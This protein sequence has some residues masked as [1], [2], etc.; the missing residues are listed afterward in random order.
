MR[1]KADQEVSSFCCAGLSQIGAFLLSRMKTSCEMALVL[2]S[3]LYLC[4]AVSLPFLLSKYGE[5]HS[6]TFSSKYCT[7]D[8]QT[9]RVCHKVWR[10]WSRLGH[11]IAMPT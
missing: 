3:A 4:V 9:H 5:I 6:L 11:L 1:L 10:P 2:S 7:D 8:G